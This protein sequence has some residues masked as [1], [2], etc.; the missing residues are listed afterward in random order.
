MICEGTPKGTFA[1][2]GIIQLG[3]FV[4]VNG[5]NVRLITSNSSPNPVQYDI[6]PHCHVTV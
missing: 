2:I 3:I 6:S 1:V 4:T 5:K